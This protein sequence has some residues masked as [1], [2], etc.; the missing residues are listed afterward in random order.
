[1][2]AGIIQF[3]PELGN[4]E[5]NYQ[6]TEELLKQAID[7]DLIVLPEL[8]NSG[9]NFSSKSQALALSEPIDDSNYVKL[10]LK[11]AVANNQFIVAGLNERSGEK[12]YNTAVLVG[13]SGYIGKYRKTHLFWNEFDFFEKGDTGFPVFEINNTK[14]GILIC[15]DWIFPEAWRIL[16][17]RGAEIICHPSNLVLPYAQQAVPVQCM[18]N[19]VYGLTANRYGTEAGVTFSGRSFVSDPKGKM[20]YT[21]P[22]DQ[23]AVFITDIDLSLSNDKMITPRNHALLDRRPEL[24]HPL[25]DTD[26]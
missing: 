23:D 2:K 1:M 26:I 18:M 4:L 12:L 19:R 24:Y 25:T 6:K 15:F 3:A 7:A 21:A 22:A 9:Y 13:P 8:A 5:S 11:M 17:L 14:I 16:A 20:L 10:L